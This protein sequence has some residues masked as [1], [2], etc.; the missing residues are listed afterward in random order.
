MIRTYEA[1]ATV[2]G[3]DGSAAGTGY[4]TEIMNGRIVGVYVDYTTQPAT[5]DV[6]ITTK[7]D[8]APAKT[9]LTLT[10]ANTDGWFYPRTQ[11][12]GPTGSGLTYD[13]TRTIN[14][15]LPVDDYGKVVVAQGNAGSVKVWFEVEQ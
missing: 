12:Q 1:T 7:G 11:V 15:A 5:C 6:T 14:E 8:T 13:G 10:D 2:A 3:A 4:T 9:I